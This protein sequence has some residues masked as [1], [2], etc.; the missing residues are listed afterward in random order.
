MKGPPRAEAFASENTEYLDA[1]AVLTIIILTL[2]W[3]S[4]HPAIKYSNQGISPVFASTLRSVIA[5]ICG[6]IYCIKRGEKL[7]QKK[8]LGSDLI[9]DFKRN[10]ENPT[11]PADG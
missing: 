1:E 8:E 10:E 11:S 6:M 2:I 5:S 3:G 9:I 7:F 4:N